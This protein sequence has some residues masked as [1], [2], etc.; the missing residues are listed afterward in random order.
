MP[1]L[2]SGYQ[3]TLSAYD[4]ELIAVE[5]GGGIRSYNAAGRPV[6]DGYAADDM[7]PAGR[8]QVLAPWP[9]RLAGGTFEW[10]GEEHH[11]PLSEAERGNAIH[12]LVRWQP[13]VLRAQRSDS[14]VLT[15]R[16][17]PQP[18]WPWRLDLLV[19]YRLGPTGLTVRTEVTNDSGLPAPFGLGWHPYLY[20]FGGPVD[21]VELTLP[22]LTA[23]QADERGIPTATF[24]VAGTDV[25]FTS[26]K[27]VAGARL[28]TCFGDLQRDRAGRAV[29]R[30][31]GDRSG[32]AAAVTRL[33]VDSSYS[34]LMVFSGDTLEAGR[35]RTALAVEPMTCA[36]NSLRSGD[37]LLT[38]APGQT[39][40]AEWG[41]EPG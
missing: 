21:E 40:E 14:A 7:C 11:T 31:A 18:G 5:V 12:G 37:G 28:D 1:T 3:V 32:A 19:E 4:Q 39:F 38:L 35:R 34:H 25:D 13:W 26:A 10:A 8:G 2:P 27:R 24:A 16:L 29:V 6:I 30:M 15:H 36:P 41:I 22:A 20:A 9:N 23:Y 33:W 17:H